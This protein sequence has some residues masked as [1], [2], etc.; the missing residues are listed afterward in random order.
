ML[1]STPTLMVS[2]RTHPFPEVTESTYSVVTIGDA[3]G[4][5]V[6]ALLRPVVGLQLYCMGRVPPLIRACKRMEEPG[7]MVT[8]GPA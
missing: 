4:S 1:L 5:S 8:S 2:E 6:V 7:A 3:T